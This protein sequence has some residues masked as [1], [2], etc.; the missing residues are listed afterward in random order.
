MAFSKTHGT[1][2]VCS[3]CKQLL[4]LYAWLD[5][6]SAIRHNFPDLQ[7]AIFTWPSA[8]R[9][10]PRLP[11]PGAALGIPQD[12]TTA[13]AT[14]ATIPWWLQLCTK[15]TWHC[16]DIYRLSPSRVLS[17]ICPSPA[18]LPN[19]WEPKCWKSIWIIHRLPW[20]VISVTSSISFIHIW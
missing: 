4:Y 5:P 17:S 11:E 14:D 2:I 18:L 9:H 12:G 1:F 6:K 15:V 16:L 8:T 19:S 13:A 20:T 10:M 3:P 7:V